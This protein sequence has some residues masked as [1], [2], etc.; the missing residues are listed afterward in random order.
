VAGPIT[1]V[2]RAK[3]GGVTARAW[4]GPAEALATAVQAAVAAAQAADSIAL[5]DAM[6]PCARIDPGAMSVVLGELTRD[7]FERAL[8]DGLDADD[9]GQV[10]HDVQRGTERWHA[11][12][13]LGVMVVVL[14]DSLG[15]VLVEETPR[16][17]EVVL[18][19]GVLLVAH[20]LSRT[21]EPLSNALDRSLADLHRAQTMELP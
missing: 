1:S 19:H 14:S 7:L 15:V 11:P 2:A 8:P 4:N 5:D 20:L 6:G 18:R 21:G 3:I 16:R 12:L 9:V 13:D 17:A 10:L